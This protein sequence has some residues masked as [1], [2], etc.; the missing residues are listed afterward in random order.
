MYSCFC[1]T[2]RQDVIFTKL[3]TEGTKFKLC[4]INYIVNV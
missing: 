2:N 4:F 3:D 1:A